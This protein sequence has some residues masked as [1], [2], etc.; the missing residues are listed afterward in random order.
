[1]IKI[2]KVA[3]AGIG[4]TV[5]NVLIKGLAFLT[6][7]IFTRLMSLSDY[8]LYTTYA[9]YE[10]IIVLLTSLGL[11]SSLKSANLCF[12]GKIEQYVSS[13]SLLS[14]L[15]TL[16]FLLIA[17]VV[18]LFAPGIWGF[19]DRI[20]FIMIIQA[21]GSA[22][23][24]MYNCRVSLDFSYKSF[25]KIS[26]LSSVGNISL[27]LLFI[28]TICSGNP[29]E[30]RVYG[31]FVPTLFLG[32]YIY[33]LFF[34]KAKPSFNKVFIKY[35]IS[36]GLPLVPHGLS[37][38]VLSQFG[39][40]IIQNKIGNEA[41]GLYGLAYTV[42]L[43][44]Q[45]MVQSLALAWGPWFFEA[46]SNDRIDTIKSKAKDY[47]NCFSLLT[48]ILFCVSPELIKLLSNRSYWEAISIVCPAILGVY[49]VFLYGL[50]V[51]VEYY[52]K[53]TSYLAT[54]TIIAAIVD[55]ILCVTFVPLYGYHAAVYATAFT[56]ALYLGLHMYIAYRLTSKQLPFSLKH[57]LISA[58]AVIIL[59]FTFQTFS[60]CWYI[61]YPIT[62]I[63]MFIFILQYK[64]L[65][66]TF[67]NKRRLHEK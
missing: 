57:I 33:I 44:P 37:Q 9:A 13:V 39:K 16:F 67:V 58:I 32:I 31:T 23:I 28:L 46:Y 45:I 66:E 59:C 2:N 43:I 26:L 27:S 41:A 22:M 60:D 25:L 61:R 63:V 8:G 62:M 50:P 52:Y 40:I 6:L 54:G 42:A 34:K 35:G 15:A 17:Y 38:L 4:Y 24:T 5:G 56:Y 30:G 3:S 64:E 11:P 65:I 12:P 1:M 53:K 20:V 10:S 36:Y 21:L 18:S 29:F 51:E 48:I 7:P 49:F 47:V 14:L 55:I 19:S